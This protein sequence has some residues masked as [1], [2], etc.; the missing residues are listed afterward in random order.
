MPPSPSRRFAEPLSR[1]GES[2][3]FNTDRGSHSTGSAFTGRLNEA[4]D[5]A[6]LDGRRRC[7]DDIAI[8]RL[9]GSL[10]SRRSTSTNPPMASRSSGS[11]ASG[12]PS[13][14]EDARRG[15]PRPGGKRSGRRSASSAE[16]AVLHRP[17][18]GGCRLIN[19]GVHLRTDPKPSNEPGPPHPLFRF[20][21]T[22]LPRDSP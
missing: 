14:T 7:M 19:H 8:E 1:Y 12:S 18:D 4:A 21:S 16:A 15:S 3:I 11:P 2:A 10:K 6:S 5:A 9:C 20:L 17:R 13:A 22:S